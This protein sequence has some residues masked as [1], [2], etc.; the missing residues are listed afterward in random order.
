MLDKV[1]VDLDTR[2]VNQ[3]VTRMG[4][5]TIVLVRNDPRDIA[6]IIHLSRASYTKMVQN[7]AW[8]V[9]YN[10]IALPLA[11][12]VL[13]GIGFVLPA[14]V[15]AVLMSLST[16]IVAINAQTLRGL[17]L[18]DVTPPMPTARPRTA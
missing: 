1:A 11:A 7:L 13:A 15:G 5:S 10:A 4:N 16:I 9:G 17:N 14:W 18:Q 3:G 8:A 2:W 12:G 6:R